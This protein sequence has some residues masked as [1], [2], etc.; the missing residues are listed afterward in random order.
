MDVGTRKTND[1]VDGLSLH[2]VQP[3]GFFELVSHIVEQAER[4]GPGKRSSIPA[5]FKSNPSLAFQPRDVSHIAQS[6]ETFIDNE[7]LYE[8]V[9][10]FIGMHGASSPIPSFYTEDMLGRSDDESASRQFLDLFNHRLIELFF[11]IWSKYQVFTRSQ[12]HSST[13]ERYLDSIFGITNKSTENSR[14]LRLISGLKNRHGMSAENLAKAMKILLNG[15]EVE[16][17]ENI[18]DEMD[19]GI[20]CQLSLGCANSSLG[21]NSLAGKKIE[22][23]NGR[24]LLRVWIN[25]KREIEE[26]SREIKHWLTQLGLS[27]L[28]CSVE[29]ILEPHYLTEANLCSNNAQLGIVSLG[30]ARSK[31]II[32]RQI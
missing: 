8:V 31:T 9:V 30:K 32:T 28:K 2:G 14:K 18:K 23:K 5:I 6:R 4:V 11:L 24:F 29:Y 10:N 20:D 7:Y 13:A 12:L 21:E 15:Q 3:Y 22:T 16:I 25:K 19:I 27:Y 26:V 1:N 17:E